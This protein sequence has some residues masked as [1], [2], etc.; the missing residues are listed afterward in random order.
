MAGTRYARGCQRPG[1]VEIR[2]GLEAREWIRWRRR[3]AFLFEQTE[4]PSLVMA[5]SRM[6]PERAPEGLSGRARLNTEVV[7]ARDRD[8]ARVASASSRRSV[9][10]DRGALHR[11][12]TRYGRRALWADSARAGGPRRGVDQARSGLPRGSQGVG[13][14]RGP[15]GRREHGDAPHRRRR[16]IPQ[17]IRGL[18]AASCGRGPGEVP[19]RGSL[20]SSR[21]VE[22]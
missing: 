21:L 12:H 11:L 5:R 20:V 22:V 2:R 7:R 15:V 4:A 8:A 13:A 14:A 6:H 18:G 9:P 1:A 17:R 19:A 3:L 10:E 16:Q